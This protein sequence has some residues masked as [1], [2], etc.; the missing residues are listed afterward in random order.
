MHSLN[1]FGNADIADGVDYTLIL[2]RH[3]KEDNDELPEK[4]LLFRPTSMMTNNILS[5]NDIDKTAERVYDILRSYVGVGYEVH[6]FGGSSEFVTSS[7][8]QDFLAVMQERKG[9]SPRHMY[10]NIIIRCE[11]WY[12]IVYRRVDEV[13]GSWYTKKKYSPPKDGGGFNMPQLLSSVFF[14]L[15]DISYNK[16][17]VIMLLNEM[18]R[19]GIL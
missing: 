7:S 16:M 2:G 13:D 18:N 15:A 1:A 5:V 19:N 11:R 8:D 12:W 6:R 10:A 4:L 3:T 14:I 17:L 9:L